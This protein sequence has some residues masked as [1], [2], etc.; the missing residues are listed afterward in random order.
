MALRPT[1]LLLHGTDP[2]GVAQRFRRTAALRTAHDTFRERPSPE[3]LRRCRGPVRSGR[4]QLELHVG[5]G[6]QI[7]IPGR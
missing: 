7:S 2:A 6:D 3:W 1:R 5:D 4:G